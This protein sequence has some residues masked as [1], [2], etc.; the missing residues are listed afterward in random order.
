VI[1]NYAIDGHAMKY[2]LSG[3]D[4]AMAVI[5]NFSKSMNHNFL[6][7]G[8]DVDEPIDTRTCKQKMRVRCEEL[9]RAAK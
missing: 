1:T 6:S 3:G 4:T 2:W 9:L 8:D 5:K 7:W